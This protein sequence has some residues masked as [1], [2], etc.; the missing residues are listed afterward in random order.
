MLMTD[1]WHIGTY[2]SIK[3]V[4]KDCSVV[5][6]LNEFEGKPADLKTAVCSFY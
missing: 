4:F 1:S 3:K 5:K 6:E 2:G